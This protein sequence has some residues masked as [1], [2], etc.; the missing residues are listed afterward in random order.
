MQLD[1]HRG[2]QRHR[3]VPLERRGDRGSRSRLEHPTTKDTRLEDTRR[4]IQRAPTVAPTRRCCI[5]QLNLS[6][7]RLGNFVASSACWACERQSAA[8]VSVGTMRWLNHFSV[9]SRT[10]SC[11]ELRSQHAHMPNG[12]S[13]ATSRCS[14]IENASTPASATR[15]PQKSTP[16]TRSCRQRHKEN[17]QHRCPRSAGP[18]SPWPR[19]RSVDEASPWS[20]T[21]ALETHDR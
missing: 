10:N 18:L 12:R 3:P 17:P 7:T 19:E 6:N 16:S 20:W 9:P 8:P 1:K 4:S 14:T 5:D 13:S 21:S 11:I 2:T 15:L